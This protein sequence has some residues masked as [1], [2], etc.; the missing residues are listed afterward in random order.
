MRMVVAFGLVAATLVACSPPN[1]LHGDRAWVRLGA[2]QGRPAAAYLNIHG[3][4]TP[5]TLIAITTDVAVKA[6]LHESMRSGTMASMK[7]LAKVA[8]PANEVVKFVPGGKHVMFFDMNPGI[9]PGST[10]TLTLTFSDGTRILQD[11][12]VIGAGDPAPKTD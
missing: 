6:E 8:I 5:T 1:Q 7:P 11:A 9:K 2:V 4:P 10:I 12:G 3:G